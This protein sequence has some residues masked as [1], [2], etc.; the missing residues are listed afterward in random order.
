MD[1]NQRPY[2]GKDITVRYDASR[3]IHAAECVRGL[4][5]VFDTEKRPWVDPDAADADAVAAVVEHCPTGA[6]T[7]RRKDGGEDEAVPGRNAVTVEANGPLV[8]R[9]EVRL[10]DADGHVLFEGPRLALCRC[11]S[12]GN[13]PFCDGS[14]TEADFRDDGR[15]GEVTSVAIN[16]TPA[17]GPL[18]VRLRA[19]GPLILE[20]AFDVQGVEGMM[21]FRGG[22]GALCRCGHSNKKPLCDGT[23]KRVL[24]GE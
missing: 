2:E 13:K 16:G 6:L 9:G 1:Q 3:C 8:L 12:S 7:Y 24:T 21:A 20:G 19:N 23:H 22:K 4:P 5:R 10:E 11:G 14:H 15:V 17:E 18:V